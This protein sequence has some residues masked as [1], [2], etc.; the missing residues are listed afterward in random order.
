VLEKKKVSGGIRGFFLEAW[1]DGGAENHLTY[2]GETKEAHINLSGANT[3]IMRN[4]GGGGMLA[5]SVD[6]NRVVKRTTILLRTIKTR[7]G[8]RG[9]N[10]E[11]QGEESGAGR[12]SN[13]RYKKSLSGGGDRQKSEW[14]RRKTKSRKN[15]KANLPSKSVSSPYCDG[16][17]NS[18]LRV[19]EED[20]KIGSKSKREKTGESRTGRDGCALNPEGPL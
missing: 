1:Q 20:L 3:Q 14:F 11:N 6:G 7:W 9:W 10:C 17:R 18:T 4:A 8:G 12:T 19:K 2:T 15:E 5:E 13:T 16:R